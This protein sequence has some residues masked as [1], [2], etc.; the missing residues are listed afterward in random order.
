MNEYLSGFILGLV[1]GLTEF[2]PVS[3][4]GHL[5][6]LE[7]MGVGQESLIFNLSLHLATLL[8]VIFALRKQLWQLIKHPTCEKMQFILLASVPTAIMAGLIRYFVPTSAKMLPFC[9]IATA[10][11]LLLPSIIRTPEWSLGQKG[12]VKRA[13]FAGVAQGVACFNGIS[14]SGATTSAM[15]LVGMEPKESAETSFLMSIPIIL[16]SAAVELITG[17]ANS[18]SWGSLAV[19]AATAFTVGL[20]AIYGFIKIMKKR[21]LWIFSIYTFLMGIGSF[22]ILSL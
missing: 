4:S 1:Q 20:A 17:G 3:S 5:V 13:L 9:F 22:L 21:K 12:M 15:C 10:V 19:G 16:G 6:L 11:I 8:A 14:R 18:V 7:S 2:L